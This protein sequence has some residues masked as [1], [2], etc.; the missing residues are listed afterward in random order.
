MGRVRCVINP[1]GSVSEIHQ[2]VVY[3][4]QM[5]DV[6]DPDLYAGE[7]LLKWQQSEAGQFVI[8]NA[9]DQPEWRRNVSHLTM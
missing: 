4:F 9:I 1:D 3:R 2:V 8:K 5:G 6:E 7:S